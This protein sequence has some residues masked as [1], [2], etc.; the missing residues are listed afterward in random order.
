LNDNDEPGH[1]SAKNPGTTMAHA[2][3][4]PHAFAI[5]L[6]CLALAGVIFCELGRFP[7]LHGDEAWFGLA[8]Q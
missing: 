6:G 5:V 4:V 3:A 7:G 8:A 1:S 2:I